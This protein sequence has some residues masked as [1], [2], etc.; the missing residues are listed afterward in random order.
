MEDNIIFVNGYREFVRFDL[1]LK[2]MD[3]HW[4]QYRIIIDN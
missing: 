3:Y 4:C 1:N 2:L